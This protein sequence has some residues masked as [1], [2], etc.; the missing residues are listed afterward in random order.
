M[1][2]TKPTRQ[3]LTLELGSPRGRWERAQTA[4]LQSVVEWG[5]P[6]VRARR[7]LGSARALLEGPDD[8]TLYVQYDEITQLLTVELWSGA[9]VMF[10]IDDW[11]GF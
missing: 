7:Y 9:S 6:D 4:L 3:S 1:H 5:L 10:G 8:L 11:N 2:R